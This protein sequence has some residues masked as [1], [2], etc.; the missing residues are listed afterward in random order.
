MH[1]GK[2]DPLAAHGPSRWGERWRLGNR[3]AIFG[4]IFTIVIFG[5]ADLLFD[6]FPA[7]DRGSRVL[8]FIYLAALVVVTGIWRTVRTLVARRKLDRR[9]YS[10]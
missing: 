2:R 8:A 1:N 6:Y 10:E 5:A 9:G 3:Y 7:D 4:V